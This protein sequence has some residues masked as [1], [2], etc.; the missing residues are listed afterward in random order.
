M[1]GCKDTEADCTKPI[2]IQVE[3][4]DSDGNILSSVGVRFPMKV[5]RSK[6]VGPRKMEK[7]LESQGS[8][9]GRSSGGWTKTTPIFPFHFQASTVSRTRRDGDQTCDLEPEFLSPTPSDGEDVFIY[10]EDQSAVIVL[11][12]QTRNN[13]KIG[14]FQ[15]SSVLGMS[16]SPVLRKSLTTGTTSCTWSPSDDQ[17]AS[18]DIEQFCFAAIDELGYS[19]EQ[20]C[21]RIRAT[22]DSNPEPTT[23][24]APE[25]EPEPT[26]P[27]TCSNEAVQDGVEDAVN[28]LIQNEF[29]ALLGSFYS[30]IDSNPTLTKIEKIY[31]I[32]F[33]IFFSRTYKGA[34]EFLVHIIVT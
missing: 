33:D 16:C 29:D 32:N 19:S 25:P 15:T 1:D 9:T 23:T 8:A 4:F 24:A 12:A 31:R 27:P 3:D 34:R 5:F 11:N 10:Q 20:R 21:I 22:L 7:I 30:V 14:S 26:L 28:D 2:A 13:V 18:N 6:M 17:R